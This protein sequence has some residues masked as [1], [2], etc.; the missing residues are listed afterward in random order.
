[1]RR[2]NLSEARIHADFIKNQDNQ[3]YALAQ[4]FVK[5]L[6]AGYAA[7]LTVTMRG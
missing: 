1:M 5:D 2:H 3:S 7:K 6:K 4:D